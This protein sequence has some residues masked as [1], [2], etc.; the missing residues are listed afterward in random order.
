MA[1]YAMSADSST[2]AQ[3]LHNLE[4]DL[5]PFS[6]SYPANKMTSY[7]FSFLYPLYGFH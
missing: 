5:C 1:L 4:S 3:N 2:H 7:G 6:S